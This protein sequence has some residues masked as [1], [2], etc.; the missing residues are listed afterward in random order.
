MKRERKY[1]QLVDAHFF[2]IKLIIKNQEVLLKTLCGNTNV[3][4]NQSHFGIWTVIIGDKP[5]Y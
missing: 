5:V 2:I 3:T 4:L 1:D